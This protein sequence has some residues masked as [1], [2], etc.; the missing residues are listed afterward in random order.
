MLSYIWE[1]SCNNNGVYY[2]TNRQN[3]AANKWITEGNN[4]IKIYI[5][6]AVFY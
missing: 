4:N 5:F 6:S 2:N 1:Q 3:L